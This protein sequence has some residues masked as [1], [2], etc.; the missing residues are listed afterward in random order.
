MKDMKDCRVTIIGMG[1]L[2]EYIFPCFRKSMGEG[3]ARQINAVTADSSAIAGKRERLGIDVT[4][5][6][7]LDALLRMK[8]DVIFFAPPPSVARQVTEEALVPYFAQAR[9]EGWPVPALYVFPPTPVGTYYH[10]MLGADVNV[11]HIVPNMIAKVGDEAVPDETYHLIT[12]AQDDQITAEGKQRLYDFFAPMGPCL[13][14]PP[15]LTMEVMSAEIC[16]HPITEIA[17]IIAR[18]LT[19]RGYPCTYQQVAS[20]MRYYHQKTRGYSSPYSNH[21]DPNALT[22]DKLLYWI[23]RFSN[24]WYD[25]LYEFLTENG[26]D[27]ASTKNLLDRLLDLYIHETQ[28]ETREQIE[29]KA[30]NDATKGGWLELCMSTYYAHIEPLVQ[31]CFQTYPDLNI[32]EEQYQTYYRM[33]KEVAYS[34]IDRSRKFNANQH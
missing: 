32:T 1:F 14:I 23:E 29:R 27:S 26:F 17:D 33:I 9:R 12:W 2:M 8:P 31:S 18:T 15:K 3:V 4:L 6:D 11:V 20:M 24:G 13:D 19:E 22:G 34:L 25:A 30:K 28:V 21:Y 16:V 5:S 10:E 7:N